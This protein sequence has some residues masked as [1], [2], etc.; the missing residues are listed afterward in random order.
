LR[1]DGLR[2]YEAAMA[3]FADS[4]EQPTLCCLDAHDV[5]RLLVRLHAVHGKPLSRAAMA[6]TRKT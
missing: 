5:D 6:N 2:A 3:M 4:F 1:R